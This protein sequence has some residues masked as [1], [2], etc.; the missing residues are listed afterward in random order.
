MI[1]I[2]IAAGRRRPGRMGGG[3]L[4]GHYRAGPDSDTDGRV[5][6]PVAESVVLEIIIVPLILEV[7]VP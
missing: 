6:V 7:T 5:R 1:I 3:P 2:I 4:A